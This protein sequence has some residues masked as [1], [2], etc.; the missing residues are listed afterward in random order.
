MDRLLASVMK[1][2]RLL[3]RDRA[4]LLMLF[5]MPSLLVIVVSVVQMNVL[6]TMG[7]EPVAMLWVDQDQG[8]I[9]QMLRQ[10]LAAA[11][12]IVLVDHLQGQPLD[13]AGALESVSEGDYQVCLVIPAEFSQAVRARSEIAAEIMLVQQAF[14]SL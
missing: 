2:W 5:L 3:T 4:G 11:E 10:S 9:P 12:G 8:D 14:Y 7:D 6:K 1:E 13:E